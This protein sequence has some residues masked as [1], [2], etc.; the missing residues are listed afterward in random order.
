MFKNG[1]IITGYEDSG[2]KKT[3]QSFAVNAT[4]C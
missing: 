3:I 2:Y 4:D 1:F